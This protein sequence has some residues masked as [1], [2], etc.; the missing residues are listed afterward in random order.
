MDALSRRWPPSAGV[1]AHHAAELPVAA[2]S[3]CEFLAPR[4]ILGGI[5]AVIVG[6][7]DYPRPARG[8]RPELPDELQMPLKA[9]NASL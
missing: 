8:S 4:G 2:R 6:N 5:N 7:S 1:T 9:L 3:P